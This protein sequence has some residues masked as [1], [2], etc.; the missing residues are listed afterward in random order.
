[1]PPST[2]HADLPS[3]DLVDA[4]TPSGRFGWL[5]I[6]TG[7]FNVMA[8]MVLAAISGFVV[9]ASGALP[10]AQGQQIDATSPTTTA[11]TVPRSLAF[12]DEPT[13][14]TPS[15]SDP[16]TTTAAPKHAT[17]SGDASLVSHTSPIAKTVTPSA[18]VAHCSDFASQP[19]AQSWFDVAR[20][21]NLALDGDGDGTACE[22]LPGRLA[23]TTTVAPK[24]APK[25]LSKAALLRPDTKLFGVHTAQAPLGSEVA[26]FATEAGKTPNMVMFFRDLDDGFPAQAI[27]DSWA[28]SIL[29]MVTLEPIFK[30]SDHG[31]PTL[32]DIS[33]G[34]YDEL[35]T[36]WA[37]AAAAQGMTF[38]L[39]FAQEMNGSWYS[40]SDGRVGNAAGEYIPA[41]RHV[42]DL[43]DAAGAN[44]VIWVWSVNR[45]DNLPDKTLARVYPGDDFVDWVGV[46]GYYRTDTGTVPSFNDT[47]ARTLNE[48]HNV[49]PRKLVVLTEVGAG[50]GE[51]NRV[52]WINDFF[53][54]LL[55]HP[56]I[57][58]FNWF[59]DFKD[60]GD[61]LI[62][63]SSA[64]EAAFAAGVA[65]N[66]YG[67]LA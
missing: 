58:G 64:T 44:N 45:V 52:T 36:T 66:R 13:T 24:V 59:N 8:F 18:R 15:I 1:M 51:G 5:A 34:V 43:F 4:V 62:G 40:W 42:H 26:A 17:S 57:I 48:I 31:Q 38:A 9:L 23:P 28:R 39:R 22:E 46:S 20:A 32:H 55:E 56:E 25:V 10:S 16:T 50:T 47:F 21:A 12:A 41:W 53:A 67:P 14:S 35:L 27:S 61:W 60:G 29:P 49:A 19:L 33:S 37:N 11:L 65:N 54:K 30:N 3:R 6:G 7:P 63:Y 2:D